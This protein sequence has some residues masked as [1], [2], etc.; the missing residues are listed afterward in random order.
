MIPSI[1]RDVHVTDPGTNSGC[2]AGKV[3]GNIQ[4]YS[5][6]DES[7][8]SFTAVIFPLH[9]S[10]TE[11]ARRVDV[12]SGQWHDLEECPNHKPEV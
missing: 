7:F 8:Y 2:I 11:A 4:G 10:I 6:G 9:G 1:S 12:P 5:R 3:I